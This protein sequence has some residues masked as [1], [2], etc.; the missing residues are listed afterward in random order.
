MS[1]SSLFN[2]QS[3][4]VLG[5]SERAGHGRSVLESLIS[6]KYSGQIAVVNPKYVGTSVLG[7][8]CYGS[9]E[10]LPFVPECLISAVRPELTN[11][12]VRDAAALGTRAAVILSSGF[13]E[14]GFEG[15]EL[16]RELEDV[17]STHR[18]A[19]CGPNCMGIANYIN[20]FHPFA[21]T[22][23]T[24]SGSY[25]ANVAVV[26]QS[27]SISR[28]FL[29]SQ[30]LNVACVVSAGNQATTT[31]A[32]YVRYFI[33][34]GHI[35]T[36]VLIIE[37]IRDTADFFAAVREAVLHGISVAAVRTGASKDGAEALISH[38]GKM[39]GDFETFVQECRRNGIVF[40]DSLDELFE[41][42]VALS[43]YG[44]QSAGGLCLVNSSGGENA[45]ILDLAARHGLTWADL[46]AE[47]RSSLEALLPT[48]A[49]VGNPL[50]VTGKLLF[51][52]E[53]YRA[54]IRAIC[55]DAPVSS[56]AIIPELPWPGS[57]GAAEPY[58]PFF[59]HT[60]RSAIEVTRDFGMPLIVCLPIGAQ[61]AEPFLRELL[62]AGVVILTGLNQAIMALR[63]VQQSR[64]SIAAVNE[65]LRLGKMNESVVPE[66]GM[67]NYLDELGKT[68]GV[69]GKLVLREIE[70]LQLMQHGE[71]PVAR[72]A[73]L[74]KDFTQ[75]P[76]ELDLQ[77]PVVVKVDAR[78]LAHKSDAG[79]VILN[80]KTTAEIVSAC[81]RIMLNLQEHNISEDDVTGF[82]VAEM[83]SDAAELIVGGR[84]DSE[85]GPIVTVGIGGIFTEILRSSASAIAPLSVSQAEV[86][87]DGL[88]GAEL[89]RGARGGQ[90][91][92]IRSA[93][94][95]VAKV[96]QIV[97]TLGPSLVELDL[98]PVLVK[99][100]KGGSF[101]GDALAVVDYDAKK[102]MLT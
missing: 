51:E 83:I 76:Y 43:G 87:I 59:A 40:C 82:I 24:P 39:A 61:L 41:T 86:L 45:H 92:D 18:L 5:A 68:V 34:T 27:G 66:E 67:I 72:Y 96:S 1:L 28:L 8:P 84:F 15:R 88:R 90:A 3:T 37:S 99:K 44:G 100:G 13:A 20:N 79:G 19:I 73:R 11:R 77:F 58:D 36:I 69:S 23:P 4:V 10:E 12:A 21:E 91:S 56:L 16:Q 57:A 74:S 31:F 35:D 6:T 48:F 101:V 32:E 22:P 64:R 25:K 65:W 63:N 94:E 98:N 26:A 7:I 38:T 14:S 55:A 71:I 60:W 80:V 89:L 75:A 2:P 54:A 70:A 46:T 93:A 49:T 29:H 30:R 78:A 95:V 102:V 62:D 97:S 33:T 42:A 50:D 52:P 17:A 53:S 85:L 9:V 47:A 81:E